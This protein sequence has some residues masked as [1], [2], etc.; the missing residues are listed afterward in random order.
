VLGLKKVS[1]S[2]TKN[3]NPRLNDLSM[4]SA[5]SE[6]IKKEK[7]KIMKFIYQLFTLRRKPNGFSPRLWRETQ[8]LNT[9]TSFL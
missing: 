8:N 9:L 7:E 4:K 5:S 6:I 3:F 2:L 1:G